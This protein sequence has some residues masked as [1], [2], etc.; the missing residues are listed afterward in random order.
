MARLSGKARVLENK[1]VPHFFSENLYTI[2][3]MLQSDLFKPYQFFQKQFAQLATEEAFSRLS[4]FALEIN[5][6]EE[7]DLLKENSWLEVT[8]PTVGM[9]DLFTEKKS[10][11]Q[12]GFICG[13]NGYGAVSN[14]KK[15]EEAYPLPDYVV[16]HDIVGNKYEIILNTDGSME[17]PKEGTGLFSFITALT[18]M[19]SAA[20]VKEGK[21]LQSIAS[22]CKKG[23]LYFIPPA[24][25][26]R[27]FLVKLSVASL[28]E[29]K[30]R[31]VE[32]IRKVKV[33]YDAPSICKE[34]IKVT[35]RHFNADNKGLLYVEL[36]LKNQ[37]CPFPFQAP[38]TL[39]VQLEKQG[40]VVYGF[41]DFTGNRMESEAHEWTQHPIFS[42]V[43]TKHFGLSKASLRKVTTSI[44]SE[45]DFM[46][47]YLQGNILHNVKRRRYNDFLLR[48]EGFSAF[49][50]R[51]IEDLIEHKIARQEVFSEHVEA[52]LADINLTEL[53]SNLHD[54]IVLSSLQS[55]IEKFQFDNFYQLYW[56]A[57]ESDNIWNEYFYIYAPG[58]KALPSCEVEV[59]QGEVFTQNIISLVESKI[60]AET[61]ASLQNET[62]GE[63]IER[64]LKVSSQRETALTLGRSPEAIIHLNEVLDF[65]SLVSATLCKSVPTQ[66]VTAGG[67]A[68]E[69]AK[70]S[71][72]KK[73]SAYTPIETPQIH[74]QY[75][76][77]VEEH[78]DTVP[79]TISWVQIDGASSRPQ[80]K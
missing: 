60:F 57:H 52:R 25:N 80:M 40:D 27:S 30:K 68:E 78:E 46:C 33:E 67:V 51:L 12:T 50:D 44:Y 73:A 34:D 16:A 48:P 39:S 77:Q 19:F 24:G 15:G 38:F 56:G 61:H 54:S 64:N 4:P 28:N 53:D 58:M 75:V 22:D 2:P 72:K 42:N 43:V 36:S 21:G 55:E 13:L 20:Q 8:I 6:A 62:Q 59:I 41:S 31:V 76:Q 14:K 47:D 9:I 23:K 63:K 66:W 11:W 18:Y 49:Y 17:L 71:I 7:I 10:N 32:S 5:V 65:S 1:L 29:Q 79:H 35:P 26:T 74:F 45:Y 70:K 37:D 3:T 69:E